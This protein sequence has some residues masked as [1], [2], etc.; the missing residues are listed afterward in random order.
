MPPVSPVPLA[1][2][3]RRTD[4]ESRSPRGPSSVSARR[5]GASEVQERLSATG[6]LASWSRRTA[7]SRTP[8]S[9]AACWPA[10]SA[11]SPT[12]AV[13]EVGGATIH[14]LALPQTLLVAQA[15]LGLLLL[16]GNYRAAD[17]LH[18]V[19]GAVGARGRPVAVVLRAGRPAPAAPLVR[20]LGIRRGGPRRS[21]HHDGSVRRFLENR[22]VRGLAI[23]ALIALVVVVLSLEPVLAA[24]GGLL[25]IALLP[26]NRVL[27]VPRLARAPWRP[28]GVVG[29]LAARVLRCDRRS[30]SSTS[31]P[32]SGSRR[33]AATRSP[34]SSCSAAAPGRSCAP[35]APSTPT[36]ECSAAPSVNGGAVERS[37]HGA[38]RARAHRRRSACRAPSSVTPR[39]RAASAS[40]A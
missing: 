12:G 35:G 9:R 23:V 20:R 27:P 18:Y 37:E 5:R 25:R 34:S 14:L 10:P 19:Y 7:I 30:R 26:R 11:S 28:R 17:Q 38:D 33:R 31:A 4:G 8:S 32:R 22:T 3:R 15:A 39:S 16:S 29:S 40:G 1:T 21:W 36:P 2:S 6:R 13:A 24:T